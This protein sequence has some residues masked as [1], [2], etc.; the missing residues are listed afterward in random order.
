MVEG[1]RNVVVIM[2]FRIE[3]G[4]VNYLIIKEEKFINVDLSF[5]KYLFFV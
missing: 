4:F 1:R 3:I 2:I 5:F